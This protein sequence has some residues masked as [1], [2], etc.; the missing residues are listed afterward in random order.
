MQSRIRLIREAYQIKIEDFAKQ[1]GFHREWIFAAE[2]TPDSFDIPEEIIES[3][4]AAYYVPKKFILGYPYK[5]KRPVERWH[6]DER[7][8]YFNANPKLKRVL[9]ATFGY[10]DFLDP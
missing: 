7:T 5:L 1:L 4:S 10:C 3:I 6:P 8:D 2:N 9:T